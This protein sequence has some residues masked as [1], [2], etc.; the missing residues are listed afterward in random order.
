M[1]A[2]SAEVDPSAKYFTYVICL[3]FIAVGMSASLI[4]EQV[5]TQKPFRELLPK[6]VKPLLISPLILDEFFDRTPLSIP[7]TDGTLA[8]ILL[9]FQ[10]GFF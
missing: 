1:V 6:A 8:P 7:T 3:L 4:V 10:S 9:A 5:E 2:P